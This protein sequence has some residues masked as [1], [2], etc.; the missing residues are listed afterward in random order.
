MKRIAYQFLL[1]KRLI[2]APGT[3]LAEQLGGFYMLL[4]FFLDGDTLPLAF[5]LA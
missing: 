4:E 5:G 2:G 3:A 1:R